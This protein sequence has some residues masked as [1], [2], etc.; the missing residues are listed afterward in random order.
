MSQLLPGHVYITSAHIP[1]AKVI[2]KATFYVTTAE[3]CMS[4]A[5][6]DWK[7]HGHDWGCLILLQGGE[8][9]N[10]EQ[11]F[12]SLCKLKEQLVGGSICEANYW[13]IHAPPR[14]FI[15]WPQVIQTTPSGPSLLCHQNTL[16]CYVSLSKN[17]VRP[18]KITVKFYC[19]RITE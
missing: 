16:F 11:G 8:V 15:I 10:W 3:K 2:Y 6:R 1:L 9:N 19:Q 13:T 18:R 4:C 12:N 5:G 7:L 14:N 17:Q